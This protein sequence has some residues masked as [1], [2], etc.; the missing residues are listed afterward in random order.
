MT[1][2]EPRE[3]GRVDAH[4]LVTGAASGIGQAVARLAVEAGWD[5]T[6]VDRD[7]ERLP[8]EWTGTAVL[9]QV[10]D[11]TDELGVGRAFDA[12]ADHWGRAPTALVH[13]A[14]L[15]RIEPTTSLPLA[16][17]R[18]VLD[19]NATGS[20]VL[21]R[22]LARRTADAEESASIVL[23]TSIAHERGD[24]HEPAAHYSASKGAVVSLTRQLA[25]EW[26][27]LGIRVNAV[28]PGVIDTPMLR[29]RDDPDRMA[30]HLRDGVPLARLG[31]ADEVASACL[32]LAGDRS[33]Y[34]TGVVLPV[35][36]GAHVA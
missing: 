30:A 9:P 21:A 14:G 19:V 22:E 4:L 20:F 23:L 32:F 12:A 26:G 10:C 24:T 1:L 15:Y 25:V 33:S 6:A 27:H 36:G 13:A 31:T 29:L 5:V 34:I 7:A 3:G 17:W 11:V 2:N 28:S 18:E 8:P 35:D 16:E